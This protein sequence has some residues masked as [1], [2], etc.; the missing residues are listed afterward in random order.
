MKNIYFS[1]I[2]IMMAFGTV[3]AQDSVNVTFQ[4][5][6]S[7]QTISA[8]GVHVAGNWQD[9][10]GFSGEWQPGESA[11][12]ADSTGEIYSLQV[13][14][15]AGT[16]QYKYINDND[17]PGEEGVPADCG[18]DNGF[19]G[20]NREAVVS[21]DTVLEAVLFGTCEAKVAASIADDLN[22][23]QAFTIAPNPFSTTATIRFSNPTNAV[24][25]VAV[26]NIAGQVVKRFE[27]V[28]GTELTLTSTN[29]PTG[30]YFVSFRNREG[31]V[32][33]QKLVRY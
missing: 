1:L 10:A 20:F 11:M 2:A 29:M 14:I 25:Q 12:A 21:S 30:L 6:M 3:V 27:A 8:N 17:W 33:T 5:D 7:D 31:E 16:Y 13:R 15:P 9:D 24:Y 18:V 4:V 28:N 23:G 19:G 22:A 26:A 32:F